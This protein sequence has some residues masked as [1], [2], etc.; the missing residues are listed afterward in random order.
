[1][2]GLTSV[3]PVCVSGKAVRADDE[4][5][6]VCASSDELRSCDKADYKATTCRGQVKGQSMPCTKLR[7]HLHHTVL[8]KHS[9]YYC[10][11]P[12]SANADIT[13]STKVHIALRYASRWTWPSRSCSCSTWQALPKASSGLEVASSTRSSSSASTPAISNALFDDATASCASVSPSAS[14]CLSLRANDSA[15]WL[16]VCNSCATVSATV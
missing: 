11:L 6:A 5:F 13:H 4:H 7:L 16:G 8:F 10:S 14:I 2:E 15:S 12:Q 1:M 3:T 9:F